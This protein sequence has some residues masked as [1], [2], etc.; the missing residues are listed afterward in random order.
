VGNRVVRLLN[1]LATV[2]SGPIFYLGPP[3]RPDINHKSNQ[4]NLIRKS[5]RYLSKCNI[6]R[7]LAAVLN[8]V[9]KRCFPPQSDLQ[10]SKNF[11]PPNVK[12]IDLQ[13]FYCNSNKSIKNELFE[14]DLL[15]L[16]LAGRLTLENVISSYI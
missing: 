15:H 4:Y 12:T 6:L 8:F 7:R 16:N 13:P 11:L 3:P 1:K 2:F 5:C 9:Q 10:M 14:H